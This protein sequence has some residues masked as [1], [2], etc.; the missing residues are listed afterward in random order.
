M[1]AV[2]FDV[3]GVLIRT[4][5][6]GSR[7]R[8][9]QRLGLAAGEADALVFNSEMGQR[10]QRGEVP[11]T[12]LWAWVQGRLG[13]SDVELQ[14]F[15][16]EFFGGDCL[17]TALVDY[18][19]GLKPHY[20]TAIISNAMD[21]LLEIVTHDYPMADA[22]DLIVGSAY[23][24]VMKP[25]PAI[26]LRTLDR[27]GCRP[28]QAVFVDDFAHNVAGAQAVGMH[29]VHYSAGMDLPAALASM[30]VL[31]DRSASVPR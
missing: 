9:E 31:A 25:D 24:R 3:G 16:D 5:D 20:R 4:M 7:A 10:A 13:L 11:A 8:L 15:H 21:N 6:R 23:E 30:G 17:D 12:A 22:F 2:I 1:E 27:L 28:E 18:I 14:A 29:A 19:R 26:F